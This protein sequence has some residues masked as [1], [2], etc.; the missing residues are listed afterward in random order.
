MIEH[1]VFDWTTASLWFAVVGSGIYHGVNPG[2][3]WPLAVSAG[4]MG[5]GRRA[6]LASLGSLAVGHFLAMA[7]ILLPFAVM[8]MLVSLERQI[9]ICAGLLVIVFGV[10]LLTTITHHPRVLSRI[11]PSQLALWSFAAATAHGAGLMLLPIY[12][13][14]CRTGE[15][16]GSHWAASALMGGK[17]SAAIVVSVVHTIAMIVS[18]R[19]SCLCRLP[20]A[21][22]QVHFEELVQSR[23]RLGVQPD[24]CRRDR[25]VER[26]LDELVTRER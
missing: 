24:P 19:P 10:F 14:L 20:V 3:G 6:L 21:R 8:I 2:M 5:S 25:T 23:L 17:L 26:L 4:L 12:L 9:R 18:G 11:R 7:G 15:L 16:D 22:S 1:P 13:G